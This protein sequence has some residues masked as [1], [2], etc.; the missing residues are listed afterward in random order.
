MAPINPDKIRKILKENIAFSVV[1][2]HQI[3]DILPRFSQENYKL[4]EV[5]ISQ[6]EPSGGYYII[7]SGKARVVDTQKDN[8][9]LAVLK[10]G[11]GFGEQSLMTGR[12]SAATRSEE[13]RVGKECR[14]RW[15]P[16][17]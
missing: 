3:E 15:S 16:Y 9:T 2:G 17:H 10:K 6:G 7:V 5:V 12:P 11:D 14:S 1:E 8:L 13:R 4:G